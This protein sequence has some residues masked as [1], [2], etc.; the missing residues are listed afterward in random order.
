MGLRASFRNSNISPSR[1]AH[2]RAV[3]DMMFSQAVA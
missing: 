1:P 3:D 2:V